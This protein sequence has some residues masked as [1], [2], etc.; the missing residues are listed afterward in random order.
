MM[1]A[2]DN[3]L[4]S[5]KEKSQ[6][7]LTIG[8]AKPALSGRS[9]G[10]GARPTHYYWSFH[11]QETNSFGKGRHERG[12]GKNAKTVGCAYR[13]CA[14]VA[15]RVNDTHT[16]TPESSPVEYGFDFSDNQA[17]RRGCPIGSVN[18]RS[19]SVMRASVF[20]SSANWASEER[21]RSPFIPEGEAFSMSFF[22]NR[23]L[24]LD[25]YIPFGKSLNA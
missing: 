21:N 1:E 8:K 10:E 24:C 4:L 15:D 23:A 17:A 12:N 25:I 13:L 3:F 18:T 11:G 9:E 14:W 19:A 7:A 5:T 2:M 20:A 22:F 6:A 16:D